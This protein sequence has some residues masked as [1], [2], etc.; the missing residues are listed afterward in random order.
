MPLFSRPDGRI[1]PRRAPQPGYVSRPRPRQTLPSLLPPTG[2]PARRNRSAS[3]SHAGRRTTARIRNAPPQPPH[4]TI[5]ADGRPNLRRSVPSPTKRLD[6]GIGESLDLIGFP[7]GDQDPVVTG[8]NDS[9]TTH[10]TQAHRTA[11]PACRW[12]RPGRLPLASGDFALG[13]Q[14]SCPILRAGSRAWSARPLR[15]SVGGVGRRRRPLASCT[16][17]RGGQRRP[18]WL[19]RRRG[20]PAAANDWQVCPIRGPGSGRRPRLTGRGPGGGGPASAGGLGLSVVDPR[21]ENLAD[22]RR[23]LV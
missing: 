22:Y 15:G 2:R 16:G 19:G 12:V 17:P 13:C 10:V 8:T 18:R 7:A 1:G 6:D 23:L 20:L 9:S 21:S 14:A 5:P 11:G 4:A 3:R